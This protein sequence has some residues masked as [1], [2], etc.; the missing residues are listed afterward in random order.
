MTEGQTEKHFSPLFA[1]TTGINAI[2]V[3]NTVDIYSID[4]RIVR[5]KAENATG[6]QKGVYIINGKKRGC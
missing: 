6:L 1:G 4:G 3:A 2:E 5:Q